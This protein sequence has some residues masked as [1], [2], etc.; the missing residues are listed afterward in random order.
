MQ[1]GVHDCLHPIEQFTV[2]LDANGRIQWRRQAMTADRFEWWL[3]QHRGP[4][5]KAQVQ[6]LLHANDLTPFQDVIDVMALAQRH[7]VNVTFSD[8]GPFPFVD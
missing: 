4:G 6:L 3:R 8:T 2:S 1:S 7:Q 5:E